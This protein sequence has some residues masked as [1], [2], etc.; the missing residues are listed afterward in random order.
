MVFFN[1]SIEVKG[2]VVDIESQAGKRTTYY[3]VIAF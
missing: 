1:H 3:P 2:V